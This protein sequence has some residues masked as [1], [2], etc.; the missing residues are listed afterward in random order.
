M[1]YTAIEGIVEAQQ[2]VQ[3]VKVNTIIL[4][5]GLKGFYG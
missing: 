4:T 5:T 2:I 3:M 1:L